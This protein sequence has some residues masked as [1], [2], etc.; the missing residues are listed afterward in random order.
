MMNDYFLAHSD[1]IV[2][3]I[4]QSPLTLITTLTVCVYL[5]I[6]IEYIYQRIKKHAEF[7]PQ[8]EILVLQDEISGENTFKTVRVV[9]NED[10]YKCSA[11]ITS[12]IKLKKKGEAG[13]AITLSSNELI[14]ATPNVANE[15]N[16]TNLLAGVPVALYLARISQQENKVFLA[17]YG[18]RYTEINKGNY[19]IEIRIDGEQ[20]SSKKFFIEFICNGKNSITIKNIS[21]HAA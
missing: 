21:K 6:G 16:K 20:F 19:V 8:I 9:S 1:S 10:A 11:Y 3:W 5:I 4:F 12:C 18:G 13:K 15:R 17:G 14:W 2:S 7:N